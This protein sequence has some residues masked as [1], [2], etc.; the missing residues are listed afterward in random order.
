MVVDK[1]QRLALGGVSLRGDG[2]YAQ[3]VVLGD[4]LPSRVEVVLPG[5]NRVIEIP[6]AYRDLIFSPSPE[7]TSPMFFKFVD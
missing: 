7:T 3:F 2:L 5:G 4:N 6:E 1:C